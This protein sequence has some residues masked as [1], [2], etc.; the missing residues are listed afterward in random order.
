MSSPTSAIQLLGGLLSLSPGANA[1]MPLESGSPPAMA[2]PGDAGG[3]YSLWMGMAAQ[4]PIASSAGAAMRQQT[5]EKSAGNGIELPPVSAEQLLQKLDQLLQQVGDDDTDLIESAVELLR[6]GLQQATPGEGV[7]SGDP[8]GLIESD[9]SDAELLDYLKSLLEPTSVNT[10]TAPSS[11]RA[12]DPLPLSSRAK[13]TLI[14]Y[15]EQKL[16]TPAASSNSSAHPVLPEMISSEE[17]LEAERLVRQLR[18]ELETARQER[19][20]L[21]AEADSTEGKVTLAEMA[22]ADKA[23]AD[24]A[25]IAMAI[26]GQSAEAVALSETVNN[27][28]DKAGARAEAG[29]VSE[30]V[31]DALNQQVAPLAQATQQQAAERQ[32]ADTGDKVDRMALPPER[33][34]TLQREIEK[35]REKRA[36]SAA[37]AQREPYMPNRPVGE[38]PRTERVLGQ[39]DAVM[40]EGRTT[41]GEQVLSDRLRVAVSEERSTTVSARA[42]SSNTQFAEAQR[43]AMPGNQAA[44]APIAQA[45]NTQDALMQ[46]MLNP[47]WSKALGERAIM[48][49]QQG[50]RVAEVRL[51][52][53]ELGALRIRVQIHGSDQVSLSFNAPNAAVREVLEQNMPRLREMFAEQGLN[54]SDAS[55]ADQSTQDRADKEQREAAAKGFAGSV[56]DDLGDAPASRVGARKIGLIDYYA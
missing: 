17:M 14:S 39:A 38:L 16:E 23:A 50:P 13:Q 45:Q 35:E 52:P 48:M 20:E 7:V 53:P 32:A 30:A 47:A 8:A 12:D 29:K 11:S 2:L 24:Q 21:Q 34:A 51:D 5:V 19:V 55:V 18:A 15:L 36:E 27:E 49:A 43:M 1:A 28:D 42:E 4:G 44:Q 37:V 10:T 31:G 25:Q 9:M 33:P 46:K 3:F 6:L 22:N 56:S 40:P 54:L 26:S 41:S